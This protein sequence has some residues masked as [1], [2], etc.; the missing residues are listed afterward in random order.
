MAIAAAASF[1]ISLLASETDAN[2][3]KIGGIP[4]VNC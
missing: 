3:T 1:D 2:L 4:S